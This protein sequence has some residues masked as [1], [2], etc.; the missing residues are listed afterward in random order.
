MKENSKFMIQTN[1]MKLEQRLRKICKDLKPF[2]KE[3]QK[4][5]RCTRTGYCE[6]KI[7]YAGEKY[8][9]KVVDMK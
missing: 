7:D 1:K 4:P 5:Y 2:N 9:G 3:I 8:C 6:Q